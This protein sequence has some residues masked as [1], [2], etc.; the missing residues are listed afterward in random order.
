[1]NGEPSPLSFWNGQ[2]TFAG[3]VRD[4]PWVGYLVLVFT[5]VRRHRF[6]RAPSGYLVQF[7]KLQSSYSGA[8]TDP[9][10][11]DFAVDTFQELQDALAGLTIEWAEPH[12]VGTFIRTYAP[13]FFSYS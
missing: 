8:Q 7:L 13:E 6:R 3:V 11:P 9:G 12:E 4:G 10:D 1:M 5:Y 2:K